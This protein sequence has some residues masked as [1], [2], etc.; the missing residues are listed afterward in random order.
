MSVGALRAPGAVLDER[1]WTALLREYR[2]VHSIPGRFRLRPVGDAA[3]AALL[4]ERLR[5]AFPGAQIQVAA[6]TGSIL[7]IHGKP[8]A[9]LSPSAPSCPTAA[10]PVNPVPGKARS[11]FY[12]RIVTAAL[13]T[14]RALPYLFIA[15]K[16][17]LKGRLT[18]EVLDGAA[19]LVCLLRRDFKSLASIT[20]FFSLGE[21]LAAW[22]RKTSRLSLEESLALHVDN[23]W[24]RKDGLELLVP[25]AEVRTGDHVV[26]RAGATAPVDGV[27]VDGR[28]MVN[29][30]SMTGESLP[31]FKSAGASVY[32]GTVLEEG[33]LVIEASRVGDGT[34][35][36]SII[37]AIEESESVKAALQSRYERMADAIVPYN[38]LLSALVY[39]VSRDAARAGSVFLVDYSCA[40]RLAAPLA[41]FTAMREA[42]DHGVLIKGGKFME[43]VAHADV[44]VID[45]TGTLTKANPTLVEVIPFGGRRRSSVLRLSAC[46]EEHFA[47]PVGQ[48]VVRA[49]EREGIRHREEHARVEL[50]VAHGIVS[51]W[52]GKRVLIGSARFVLDEYGIRLTPEQQAVADRETESGRSVLYLAIG[53]ELAGLLLI[54]DELRD[55][56]REVT[57]AL[58]LDGVRRIVML[59]G[60]GEKTAASVA[61][62][63]GITEYRS[64]M[65]PE[66]KADFIR[67]LKAQGC[68]VA[69]VGD[70]INDSPALSA[71][72][73]GV[74]MAEGADLAREVADIV[75]VNTDLEGL[76]LARRVGRE[77]LS[78]IRRSFCASVFWNSIFLAGGL[79]GLLTPGFSA[80]LHNVTTSAI[81]V[82]CLRPILDPVQGRYSKQEGS[83]GENL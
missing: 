21:Y 2:L 76:L 81:A 28:G 8:S 83:P 30:A 41:V 75:L 58:R 1:G 74:A 60:D 5:S 73:V 56:A 51:A 14:W 70:G 46:L 3:G 36:H 64:H 12:P 59:T 42:A 35:I 67:S 57:R 47:H 6:R 24:V 37:R 71:A 32:A 23:V 66:E 15:F 16:Y 34:R 26:V 43:A 45:K 27:V 44:V 79:A 52:Q 19:L 13:A 25:L 11:F 62:A 9:A 49:A 31:A 29:Q 77:A 20:F 53:G 72:H 18:L 80:F 48:A 68:T 61:A 63:V 17:L 39:G 55:N 38:F 40:I 50:V 69:M 33:E 54:E 10:D 78:R 82:A 65:L 22:T 7:V 4:G